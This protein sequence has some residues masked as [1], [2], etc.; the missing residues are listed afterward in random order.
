MKIFKTVLM[1]CCLSLV[2]NVRL[3]FPQ[4]GEKSKNKSVSTLA[5]DKRTNSK[6]VE[7]GDYFPENEIESPFRYVIVWDDI[8]FE[9]EEKEQVPV[10]RFVRVLMEERAFNEANLIYLFNYLSNYYAK[11]QYLHIEV[12]TSLMTLETLEE[13]VA[14]STH[15]SRDDFRQFYKTAS[16]SRFEDGYEGFNYDTGKSGKFIRKSVNLTKTTKK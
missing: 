3:I 14:M 15:S 12:H 13:S 10:S 5:K 2:F 4:S 11:P 1:I 16:Y 9:E 8:R 6:K 7:P